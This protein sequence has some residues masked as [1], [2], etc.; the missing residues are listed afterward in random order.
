MLVI[1]TGSFK[2]KRL[3]MVPDKRTRY[4]PGKVRMALVNILN[5]NNKTV[6]DLCAGSGI[7]GFEFLSNG[8]KYVHFVEIS[9]K[10]VKTIAANSRILGVEKR[11]KIFKKDAR[12]F[13]RTSK[14]RYE[15][16]FTDPPFELGIVNNLLVNIS[17]IVTKDGI[18]IVEHSKKEKLSIPDSLEL[19]VTK[20]FGDIH[21]D[22]FRLKNV[23]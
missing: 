4:T 6:L 23:L 17:N 1:E 21:L 2:R 18:I 7:V 9:S 22:F 11:I 20:R 3:E 8:A 15:I 14:N 5:L 19:L 13:L 16:V 12:I 10:A